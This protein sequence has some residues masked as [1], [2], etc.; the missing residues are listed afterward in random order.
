M[1][2]NVVGIPKTK[3]GCMALEKK[4]LL[5]RIAKV[6]CIVNISIHVVDN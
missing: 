2:I 6:T 1:A 4:Y 3:K 5:S